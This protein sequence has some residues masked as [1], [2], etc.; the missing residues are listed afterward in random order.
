MQQEQGVVDSA[1]VALLELRLLVDFA[2]LAYVLFPEELRV[3]SA[4]NSERAEGKKEQSEEQEEGENG[5]KGVTDRL[6]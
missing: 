5:R 1:G 2:I 4:Q 6:K 3:G